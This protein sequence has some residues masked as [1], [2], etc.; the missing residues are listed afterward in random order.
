MQWM[1]DLTSGKLKANW[2]LTILAILASG[3]ALTVSITDDDGDGKK[4]A[5]H[6]NVGSGKTTTAKVDTADPGRAPDK[7]ITVQ[8][9]APE[10]IGDANDHDDLRTE[11]PPGVTPKDAEAIREQQDAF[12]VNDGIPT[13]TPLAAP[14]QKGCISR[15]VVNASTR[16]GVAPR[17]IVLHY[18]VSPNRAGWSDVN[19]VVALFDRPSFQ[20]SSNYVLDREAHC[21][22]IVRESDKA[23]TQAAANPFSISFEIINSGK[24]GSLIS[25]PGRTKLISIIRGISKRWNIPIRAGKVGPNCTVGTS[26]IITHARL[27]RCAGGHVDVNPY[28]GEVAGIIKSAKPLVCGTKCKRARDLRERHSATHRSLKRSNCSYDHPRAAKCKTWVA[29]NRAIH[30]AAKKEGIK[31]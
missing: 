20:A 25:G 15:F 14:T 28:E 10:A 24:E 11:N 8:A 2:I 1:T 9:G 31:L 12:A 19:N 13:V 27:G 29:R 3:V 4:D 23:W 21:A 5:I 7:T 30:A 22:Y 17:W 26:G 16:R 6:I 18:T